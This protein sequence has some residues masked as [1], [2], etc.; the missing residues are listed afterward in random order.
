M[1]RSDARKPGARQALLVSRQNIVTVDDPASFSRRRLRKHRD[2]NLVDELSVEPTVL[3]FVHGNLEQIDARFVQANDKGLAEIRQRLGRPQTWCQTKLPSLPLSS[4]HVPLVESRA[5]KPEPAFGRHAQVI[6]GLNLDLEAYLLAGL[7]NDRRMAAIGGDRHPW[8][9]S[10][11]GIV[12][13]LAEK[14]WRLP[15]AVLFEVDGELFDLT[16]ATVHR[17]ENI[18]TAG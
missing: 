14:S 5:Q 4:N 10:D 16:V 11:G 13:N 7:D 12:S 6:A 2:H 3:F 8:R 17:L 1:R 15:F 18:E 9:Y